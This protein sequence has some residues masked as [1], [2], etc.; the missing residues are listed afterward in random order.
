M[1]LHPAQGAQVGQVPAG[2]AHDVPVV[3]AWHGGGPHHGQAHR[4]LKNIIQGVHQDSVLLNKLFTIIFT[5]FIVTTRISMS[6]FR[7]LKHSYLLDL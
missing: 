7:C 2:G 5:V 3:A 6:Q 4:A 1:Q